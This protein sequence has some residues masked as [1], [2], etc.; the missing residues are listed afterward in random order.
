MI[1]H[2]VRLGTLARIYEV[3]REVNL[4]SR[5]VAPTGLDLPREQR[6]KPHGP[7]QARLDVTIEQGAELERRRGRTTSTQFALWPADGRR[8]RQKGQHLVGAT[9]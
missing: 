3:R 4:A 1:G 9:P 8:R 7:V 5:R 6:G 2:L